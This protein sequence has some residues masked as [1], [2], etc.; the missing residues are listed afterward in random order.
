MYVVKIH[1]F[2]LGESTVG[3]TAKVGCESPCS[4][5]ARAAVKSQEMVLFY[6]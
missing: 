4:T 5:L 2:G 3:R 6:C 1:G